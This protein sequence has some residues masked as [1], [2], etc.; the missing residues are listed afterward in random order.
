MSTTIVLDLISWTEV[1]F[2]DTSYI[3]Y[4]YFPMQKCKYTR[5]FKQLH[6][7][8]EDHEPTASNPIHKSI[9]ETR[10]AL[11]SLE[12]GTGLTLK[13]FTSDLN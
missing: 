10:N 5:L 13:L 6:K 2:C 3:L 4:V 1:S 7:D 9:N 11:S 8:Y 12:Q